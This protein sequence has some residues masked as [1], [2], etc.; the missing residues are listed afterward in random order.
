MLCGGY[1]APG[2]RPGVQGLR[3]RPPVGVSLSLS[4]SLAP[5]TRRRAARGRAGRAQGFSA[6]R[7]RRKKRRR[8]HRGHQG[9][10]AGW[11]E[12]EQRPHHADW[13]HVTRTS[14]GG[15]PPPA[16]AGIGVLCR[17]ASAIRR[18][19]AAR[20]VTADRLGVTAHHLASASLCRVTN[21]HQAGHGRLPE[22]REQP[23]ARHGPANPRTVSHDH[24]KIRTREATA[25]PSRA[26]KPMKSLACPRLGEPAGR[27][28]G[29]SSPRLKG[30]LRCVPSC[31]WCWGAQVLILRFGCW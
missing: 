20:Q 6:G 27:G 16:P 18:A 11:K 8:A 14:L 9:F 10:S 25:R 22:L 4:L 23:P 29:S 1:A 3:T 7:G 31:V 15:G 21:N 17:V 30:P 19:M 13:G 26:C 28:P 2:C 12:A 24:E 5:V